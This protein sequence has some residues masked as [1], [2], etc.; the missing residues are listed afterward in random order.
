M[1]L[2]KIEQLL[3][4]YFEGQTT[5]A[6]EEQ[7]RSYFEQ[8]DLPE[9]LQLY[10]P[11]FAGFQLAETEEADFDIKLPKEKINNFWFFRVAASAVIFLGLAGFFFTQ[12]SGGYSQE[13]QL[14][15]Q[16]YQEARETMMMLSRNLNQGAESVQLLDAFNTGTESIGLINQLD[17]SKNLIF[18]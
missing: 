1:E 12:N 15:L 9:H 6:E 11:M 14:A 2:V 18:K 5:L 7:L 4:A 10:Q 17:Q 13:E 16:S 8:E 3:E